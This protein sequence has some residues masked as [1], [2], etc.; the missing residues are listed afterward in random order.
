MEAVHLLQG[1]LV[2]QVV[3][4]KAL[5]RGV[6]VEQV[7]RTGLVERAGQG[8]QGGQEG[9][10]GQPVGQLWPVAPEPFAPAP[11]SVVPVVFVVPALEQRV[12]F[13]LQV[14]VH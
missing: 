1:A 8:G 14:L 13:A 5:G 2:G 9:Q 4:L 11:A 7:G 12:R 6:E 10:E 3:Q